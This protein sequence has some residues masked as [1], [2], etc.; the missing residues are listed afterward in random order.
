MSYGPVSY[1]HV[2]S[3]S[4][5]L[6][7]IP[8]SMV[9]DSQPRLISSQVRQVQ[10]PSA[11]G[12]QAPGGILNFQISTGVGQGY[13]K[14]G[15]MFLRTDV[16]V[17]TTHDCS[18]AGVS[19]DG[20]FDNTGAVSVGT[21]FVAFGGPLNKASQAIAR[22]TILSGGQVIEQVQ[23][24]HIVANMLDLHAQSKSFIES[25]SQIYE[26]T[27]CTISDATCD[28][29]KSG[30]KQTIQ[31]TIPILSGLLQSAHHLPLFLLNGNLQIQ[32]ELNQLGTL[33]TG[34]PVTVC[35][36][37]NNVLIYE[38]LSVDSVM[39]ATM[40]QS[41][42]QAPFSIPFNSF[43][44]LASASAQ[45]ATVSQPI[46]LNL[47]SVYGVL[48]AHIT[49]PTTI[50]DRK[51]FNSS[52]LT[53]IKLFADGRLVNSYVVDKPVTYYAEMN[54]VFNLLFDSARTSY[55]RSTTMVNASAASYAQLTQPLATNKRLD[56]CQRYFTVGISCNRISEDGVVM[57]GTPINQ[58]LVELQHTNQTLPAYQDAS[59]A[60]NVY[61]VIPHQLLLTVDAAG[62]AN[63]IR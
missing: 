16:E 47:S 28:V 12:D 7:D 20:C 2:P 29:A 23:N 61:Y 32:L 25:D 37:K 53:Q 41:L 36:F 13:L 60:T 55:A 22:M 35:T 52:G 46:G 33:F 11:S 27:L 24:Y 45:Y 62:M 10:L 48:V 9:S 19:V 1:P 34:D 5:A 14:R 8:T 39:E 54:K 6:M 18:G 50:A 56:Y 4:A 31:V 3:V 38:Q 58:M 21:T 42:M 17:T 43:I 49:N 51:F 40:K 44:T 30:N 59:V 15:S 57:A 26:N 63:I